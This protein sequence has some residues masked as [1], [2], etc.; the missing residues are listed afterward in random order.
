M[1][2]KTHSGDLFILR[3][4]LLHMVQVCA[5]FKKCIYYRQLADAEVQSVVVHLLWKLFLTFFQHFSQLQ[6][7]GFKFQSWNFSLPLVNDLQSSFYTAS[8]QTLSFYEDA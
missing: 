2:F 6:R 1:K 7:E 8:Y 3:I 4:T 5:L